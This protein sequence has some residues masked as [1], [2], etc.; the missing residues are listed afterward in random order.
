MVRWLAACLALGLGA[1]LL[2]G[3]HGRSLLEPAS[4]TPAPR[5]FDVSDGASFASVAQQ[6][7]SHGLIQSAYAATL[8]A[9]YNELD[10]RL[11]V[12]QYELSP[13]Q[14]TRQILEAITSGR[15]KTWRLT[16]P[17]GIRAH[18]VADRLA[19][20]GLVEAASFR[21]ALSNPELAAELGIPSLDFEGYLY[22][23]TYSLPRGMSAE[24]VVRVMVGRFDTVWQD[25][26]APLTTDSELSKHEIVTLASIVEKETASPSE[27]A[28][29]AGVFLNRLKLGMRL[30][31][32]PTVIYGID[33]FDGNLRR[34]H[35]VDRSNPYN[36]YQHRGLPPGPIANPGR[37]ALE[38][39]LDPAQT[40][41][42]YFVSKNDGTHQF[43]KTYQEHRKAVDT[44]QR[45][46]R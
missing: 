8:L 11:H 2:L 15:V 41:Y 35:L 12:G 25:Q 46:R 22:P 14:S 16:V 45:R 33:D 34:A 32:D 13:H 18:E 7:E 26:I 23:D 36:T 27:R 20:S 30:E 10:R 29:I 6:L 5:L 19:A 43:S 3:E 21:S 1:I 24:Q 31:T 17:E 38:S 28:L 37:K 9:R 42:L 44:F 40:E 39:V 4:A